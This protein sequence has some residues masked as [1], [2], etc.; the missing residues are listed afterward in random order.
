MYKNEVR[1]EE[2]PQ[3]TDTLVGK[4]S[5][6]KEEEEPKNRPYNSEN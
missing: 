6:E 3:L 1:K 5:T 4:A 2:T